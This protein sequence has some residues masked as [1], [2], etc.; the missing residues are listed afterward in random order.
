M[1][2]VQAIGKLAHGRVGVAD[3]AGVKKPPDIPIGGM[4]SAKSGVGY[5]SKASSQD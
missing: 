4:E 2:A 1:G 3:A 5:P